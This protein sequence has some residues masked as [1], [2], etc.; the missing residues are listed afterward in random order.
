M[1]R[2]PFTA[3]VGCGGG[4]GGCLELYCPQENAQKIDQFMAFLSIC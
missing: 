4:G 1:T 2:Y 3:K